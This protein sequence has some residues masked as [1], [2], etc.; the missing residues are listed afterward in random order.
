MKSHDE[1]VAGWMEDPSFGKSTMPL[2][3]SFS[4]C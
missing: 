2:M 1:M 4:I 3:M